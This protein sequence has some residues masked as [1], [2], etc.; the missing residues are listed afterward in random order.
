MRRSVVTIAMVLIVGAAHAES[1]SEA[2]RAF[3]FV[4][5]WS[6]DCAKDPTQEVGERTTYVADVFGTPKIL[7]VRRTIDGDVRR[8]E[9]LIDSA[10]RVTDEKIKITL[11]EVGVS[12]TLAG[13]NETVSPNIYQ[14]VWLKSASKMRMME[15]LTLNTNTLNVQNGESIERIDGKERD[16]R[17]P[18]PPIEKCIN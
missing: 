18:T 8:M 3:G 1:T 10:M 11:H 4:G 9:L 2:L 14:V 15:S 16:I 6:T 13:K 5:T 7:S 12:H 17:P